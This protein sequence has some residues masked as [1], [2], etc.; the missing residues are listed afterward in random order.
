MLV[1]RVWNEKHGRSRDVVLGLFFSLEVE[2]KSILVI[3]YN[4]AAWLT[5]LRCTERE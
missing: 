3:F 4:P 1:A 5:S 2:G